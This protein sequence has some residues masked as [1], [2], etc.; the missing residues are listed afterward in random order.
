M[1]GKW[2][3]SHHRSILLTLVLLAVGGIFSAF[4]VPVGLFPH[5]DFPRIVVTV[6][7]GDRP[8]ERMGVEVTWPLEEAVRA[9]PGVRSV[10]STTTRGSADISVNFDWSTDTLLAML[11]VESAI[12]QIRSRLPATTSFEVRRM[13]PTVFPVLGYSLVS[14]T[15][16]LVE[17]RDV[18]LYQL[19]PALS[20]IKGVSKV[21]VLGGRSAEL[22]VLVDPGRLA[23]FQMTVADVA[24]AV[25]ASNVI[26]AVGRIESDYKLYLV[27]ANTQFR[28]TAEV[29]KTILRSGKSGIVTLEDVAQVEMGTAPQWR[30]VTAD[31]QDAVLFQIYQQPGGN[32]VQIA[33]DCKTRLQGLEA[34]IPSGIK[35]SNWYDQS[36]LIVASALSARDALI[37]GVILAMLTLFVFLANLRVTL[38]AAITV[39]IVLATLSLAIS[40]FGMG[41]NIMTLGGMAAAVGLIIDDA[42][43]MIEHIVRRIRG[44]NGELSKRITEAAIEFTKPL[45]GSSAS[46]IIIFAPLAFLSGVTGAFFKALSLTM[47]L[48]LAIS[49]LVAWLAVPLLSMHLLR[50]KDAEQEDTGPVFS[51]ITRAYGWLLSRLIRVSWMVWVAIIPFCLLGYSAYKQIG[52][53]FIPSMDE[54]GFILDYVA[55]PGTSLSETDRLLRQVED[56]LSQTKDVATWSRRTG[57]SLGGA[58]TEANEGDF[59][60]R[61]APQPR[62]S[63]DAVMV[64][65][66]DRVERLVPGLEIELAKLMEDLIGDL[67]AVPQPI[68]IK[69]FSDDNELLR[70]IAPKVVE[71]ISTVP[72]VVDVKDGIVF[73]GD[74]LDIEVSRP[75]AALEGINPEEVSQTLRSFLTGLV[76]TQVQRGPKMIGLRVW[77]PQSRRQDVESLSRLLL[78]APDGHMFPLSRIGKITRVTGQPQIHRFDLK[79]MIAVTARIS[80]RD[81][82]STVKDVI[83]T[84][85]K[86]GLFPKGVYYSLGGL[87]EQQRIAFRGL[88][89]VFAAAVAL[90]FILLL[91][92]YESFRVAG[93]M[94]LTAL[95]AISA[96]FIGLRLTGTELNITSI[97]GMTMVIGIVTEV[98][99]FY[100]SEYLELG[101]RGARR[102][103]AVQ[104]GQNR[105]RPILMTTIAAF[106]ALLPLALGLGEGAAMLQP[107]A[108]AILSGL[109]VQVFLVL[110]AFPLFLTMLRAFPD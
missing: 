81:L 91:Y 45:A 6:D 76:T 13:D 41:Y 33:A 74:A 102:E 61:L 77:L 63:L 53:G 88:M 20:S 104:A 44:S 73:A 36:D 49:F 19:R 97:M 2:A 40:V 92:L 59:F 34:S 110:F 27:L 94:M 47:A 68:E 48:G 71:R 72:G 90:V 56:I 22:Q 26:Q 84:L 99:I 52:S 9:V 64:E 8:A 101:S 38:I 35:I 89:A 23:S 25:S 60:I 62:R 3:H 87:Y 105:L 4:G 103:R 16:S 78:T 67:T 18:A 86:P 43:V 95:I 37:Y 79:G 42:I 54:G 100:Y 70:R 28:D 85:D 58:I 75:R 108:I 106:L 17:M 14:D 98:T 7:A 46:T 29:G 55:G 107:L 12:N 10:R 109:S 51:V 1:I 31:G 30:R 96:V 39:P 69:V 21:E 93:A 11:Q 83:Q 15:R 80:D 24:N 66:R 50:E 32:T 65:V 82:G 5:V 57:L